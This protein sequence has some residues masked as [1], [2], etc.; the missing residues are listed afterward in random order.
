M[1]AALLA[2]GA[3]CL[4][5]VAPPRPP[6][7]PTDAVDVRPE[8]PTEAPPMPGPKRPPVTATPV[9]LASLP[10]M[11]AVDVEAGA[12]FSLYTQDVDP[13]CGEDQRPHRFVGMGIHAEG[14]APRTVLEIGDAHPPFAALDGKYETADDAITKA[15]LERG[16]A[17]WTSVIPKGDDI[18]VTRYEGRFDDGRWKVTARSK[19][20]VEPRAIVANAIYGYRRG[21]VLGIIAPPAVWTSWSEKKTP[22]SKRERFTLFEIPLRAGEGAS[23]TL[24][25]E[26]KLAA[27]LHTIVSNA[28]GP[29]S[30]D[31]DA[32]E[33]ASIEVVWPSD[34]AE[35]TVYVGN[36]NAHREQITNPP[37]F[38]SDGHCTNM[39]I[40]F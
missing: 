33:V 1:L 10:T 40:D 26:R 21:D 13:S 4:T 5:E 32:Y 36:A 20:T 35:L 7:A 23:L 17:V 37:T 25:Y 6:P 15:R 39:A 34:G 2:A 9:D 38:T 12:G 8:P 24:A 19:W 22:T 31:L 27:A 11:Q 16:K 28:E 18:T 14:F 29:E 3:S 30:L